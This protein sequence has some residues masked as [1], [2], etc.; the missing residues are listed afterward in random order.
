[1]ATGDPP[2]GKYAR[3]GRGNRP[4]SH[5]APWGVPDLT[6]RFPI[7]R[8]RRGGYARRRMYRRPHSL[9][10]RRQRRC[11]ICSSRS[12]GPNPLQRP[13][14]RVLQPRVALRDGQVLTEGWIPLNRRGTVGNPSPNPWHGVPAERKWRQSQAAGG[15]SG[16]MTPMGAPRDAEAGWRTV[17]HDQRATLPGTT[18]PLHRGHA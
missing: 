2:A 8:R 15:A 10:A 16:R 4:P 5:L 6:P 14:R 7:R 12:P 17:P 18:Q 1:M 13:R 9:A 11:P 3:T